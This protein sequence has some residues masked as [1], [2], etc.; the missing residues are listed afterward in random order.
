MD[1]SFLFSYLPVNETPP[2]PS[3]YVSNTRSLTNKTDDLELLLSGHRYARDCCILLITETWLHDHIPDAT[4]QL[5]HRWDRNSC[6]GKRRGGGLC[7]Y[8]HKGWCNNSTVLKTHCSSGPGVY[9]SKMQTFFFYPENS[10]LL[11]SLLSNIPPDANV[12][13]ALSLL[14]HHQ[15]SPAGP[16]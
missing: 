14:L 5:L 15:H 8:M 13:T 1:L 3:L 11:L 2:L 9:A 4:V 16:P 7:I 12:S 6:S 10:P